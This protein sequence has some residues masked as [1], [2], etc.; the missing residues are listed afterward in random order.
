MIIYCHWALLLLALVLS[1]CSER[2][3]VNSK[4]PTDAT[5]ATAEIK[6]SADPDTASSE[7]EVTIHPFSERRPTLTYDYDVSGILAAEDDYTSMLSTFDY[8]AK[9]ESD[10]PLTVAQRKAAY[11][12]ALQTYTDKEVERLKAAFE[13]TFERMEGMKLNLPDTIHIFSEGSVEAGAAYTRANII[14]MPKGFIE[15][16]DDDRLAHL[17]AHEL[18]HVISRYNSELRPAMYALVGHERVP[19][20]EL[21]EPLKS[22]TIANPDAPGLD[23][24]IRCTW[25]DKELLFL[26][27]LHSEREY[28][29][30]AFFFYMND[31]LLAIEVQG[32]RS[33]VLIEN[34]KPLIVSKGDVKDYYEQ[35]GSNTRY[36]LHPE[37]TT[38]EHFKILLRRNFDSMPN[39]EMIRELG[40]LLGW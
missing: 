19:A 1:S 12:K 34:N 4:P 13:I 20:P 5:P 39:P 40:K 11:A 10:T 26:P 30:G 6:P 31:D 3:E 32:D 18:F 29:H 17:A 36:H 35:V 33:E 16:M 25:K 21:P 28:T 27:I 37:E 14:C 2:E 38:A 7:E 8:A 23:Y 15:R 9:F 22:M 24:A